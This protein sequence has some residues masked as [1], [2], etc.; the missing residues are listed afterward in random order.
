M[1][2]LAAEIPAKLNSSQLSRPAA[3]VTE[4]LEA[5]GEQMS[6]CAHNLRFKASIGIVPGTSQAYM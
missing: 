5:I 1:P 4:A 3:D 6:K 2:L